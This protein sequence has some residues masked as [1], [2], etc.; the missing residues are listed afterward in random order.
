M[1]EFFGI[2][3]DTQA[4]ISSARSNRQ[5]AWN[6]LISLAKKHGGLLPGSV[7][8]RK[9][10][11]WTYRAYVRVKSIKGNVLFSQEVEGSNVNALQAAVQA[12]DAA[13]LLASYLKENGHQDVE[14]LTTVRTVR[15]L[16]TL[17]NS[18]RE[19]VLC[20]YR[21][22]TN[23]EDMTIETARYGE[24]R[25]VACRAAE[26]A[27]IELGDDYGGIQNCETLPMVKGHLQL[28]DVGCGACDDEASEANDSEPVPSP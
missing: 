3:N 2:G 23:K 19:S 18:C 25:D 4:P 7:K 8:I 14:V 28:S 10:P 9:A 13:N 6:G 26:T 12:V 5:L 27:A 22:T 24:T 20:R 15:N 1:Y 21:C 11:R 17:E 16:N